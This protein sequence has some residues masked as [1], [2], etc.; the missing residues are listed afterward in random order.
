M[1]FIF[2]LKNILKMEMLDNHCWYKNQE[3]CTRQIQI[4]SLIQNMCCSK[5][6]V[7]C[8]T[9]LQASWW[10]PS[11]HLPGGP[12]R[13]FKL[14]KTNQVVNMVISAWCIQQWCL[15]SFLAD[16]EQVNNFILVGLRPSDLASYI[17]PFVPRGVQ[18]STCLGV[19][20]DTLL[21]LSPQWVAFYNPGSTCLFLWSCAPCGWFLFA[22]TGFF[23]GVHMC[24]SI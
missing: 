6:V 24:I 11:L 23:Q 21:F 1:S 9:R 19:A 12:G 15:D 16:P 10:W 14:S 8:L 20:P 2:F 22:R 7:H 3:Q 4:L 13:H 18:G 17:N 5:C